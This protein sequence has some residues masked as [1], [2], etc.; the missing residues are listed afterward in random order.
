MDKYILQKIKYANSLF[1]LKKY[2]EA[3]NI[4]QEVF[5][6]LPEHIKKE[7][8]FNRQLIALRNKKKQICIDEK[9][10]EKSK[11]IAIAIHVFYLDIFSEILKAPLNML[12]M[13]DIIITV[14][15]DKKAAVEALLLENNLIATIFEKENKGYDILPFLE[16]IDY[17]IENKYDLILKLHTKKGLANLEEIYPNAGNIWFKLL[18]EP[19][20]GN[21][22][23][24]NKIINHFEENPHI[25]MLGS[26][27]FYKS[28]RK[29][30]Y[31]NEVDT[32][33][34]L[35]HIA[36]ER[37]I[38]VD[39]GFFAGSIFWLKTDVLKPL[40]KIIELLKETN[41]EKSQ[42]GSSNSLWHSIERIFGILPALTEHQITL[43][44]ANS[45][46]TIELIDAKQSR[47]PIGV[48]YGVGARLGGYIN[49]VSD[50]E[51]I[52]S[53]PDF[54]KN[55]YIKNYLNVK[56]LNVDPLYHY[57]RY[58]VYESCNPN[59]N[60][61]S[62][63]YWEA[64]R[65]V[66]LARINPLVHYLRHGKS[67]RPIF[68]AEENIQA[69]CN[70]LKKSNMFDS[71]FYLNEYPDVL[72][73]KMDPVK[74]YYLYGWK[75]K[76]YPTSLYNFDSIWYPQE[77]LKSWRCNINPLLHY[78]VLK[79]KSNIYPKPKV[80]R[81]G[82]SNGISFSETP[83]RI[84]LF[85]GYDPDGIIDEYV[86]EFIR[87]LSIYADVYYLADTIMQ[88]GELNK[89]NSITQGAWSFRHGEYDFGS[90]SRLA[91]DLVGWKLIETYDELLLVNDSSYL[92]SSLK[93]IFDK[94]N[95]KSCDWWG[96]QA[97]K[98]ISATR[99]IPSN[100]FKNKI[101][102]DLVLKNYLIN[103]EKDEVYDF[104]IGSYFLA[105]RK[106]C[107]KK[108]GE[109]QHIINNV[110]KEINKKNI[111][112]TYEIGLTRRLIL[113]GFKP[114][115][116]IDYLYPFHP[117][118]TNYHFDLIKNGFPLFK[119]FFLT[120]NHYFVPELHKWKEKIKNIL[121]STNLDSAEKN[122]LR[123][124]SP[125]K[126]YKTLNIPNNNSAWPPPLLS[127]DDFVK[128]DN[129]T[130][131]DEYCWAFPV[132][133]YDH[134]LTGNDRMV[135][136]S[137]RNNPKIHKIILTRSKHIQLSGK[138][139]TII[140]LKS[141][142][143]QRYLMMAKYIFIKHTPKENVLYPLDSERHKFIN[144]WHGIPLK[145]IGYT[146][147]DH[148]EIL[149]KISKVNNYSYTVIASSKVDRMAMAVAFYPLTYHDIWITGLPRNDVIL[150]EE[151]YLPL[152][153]QEQLIRLR[154]KL[155]NRRLILFAPTFRNKQK[156][157]YY[158]F[159]NAEKEKLSKLLLSYNAVL[160]VREHMADKA[161]SYT[162]KLI[163]NEMPVINLDKK[164]FSDIELIYRVSDILITDY[165]SCF[166]DFMLTGKPQICFAFDYESYAGSERGLFYELEDIFPG[167]VCHDFESLL[168]NLTLALQNQEI[169]EK[170]MYIHKR[171]IF[172]SYI[173]DKNT[174]RLLEYIQ[175]DSGVLL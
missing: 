104:H 126:L 27:D 125:E 46:N 63:Y 124:T 158:Q 75:E 120:E 3:D 13:C 171:K 25:G 5:N 30:M 103:Y 114:S 74:H 17:F 6:N 100:Q 41:N 121:P 141:L 123:I 145:R 151:Q 31:G 73:A 160:G 135:F 65:D 153:F 38:A 136:E 102:F 34:I 84:C 144:L 28:A 113:A 2:Q 112:L 91:K 98:G 154:Q 115:T 39:W 131:Q 118:Y 19:I 26:A 96:L 56:T 21:T 45:N 50:Y 140:P 40:L 170:Q 105:F 139:L 164:Y 1:R 149:D 8:N 111:I 99:E 61:S 78:V 150:R 12:N 52:E 175:K 133:A 128:E 71:A 90:Y 116:F 37:D 159:N 95:K 161:H 142:M 108:D 172:F 49:L 162:D 32:A 44:Y 94:M 55:F 93:P 109:L 89:L 29:L 134:L 23:Q 119:R 167:P 79:E 43:S 47:I 169:E 88:E 77:Y 64:N 85:A 48:P 22:D 9:N 53:T 16:L 174:D 129:M 60:F 137:V 18:M 157:G 36:P 97:T 163:G 10:N 92:I 130:T 166:I 155:A 42:T 11:K 152:D 7:I 156:D 146:S 66:S 54:D 76:R 82:L 80:E 127:N 106:P 72:R 69:I 83:K 147:L 14:S 59:E 110:K 143:G 101:P 132:C 57:L 67:G 68:P 168:T 70:L 20:F 148:I 86:V 15:S 24:V 51:F 117:I 58:G 62:A 173:D 165:S 33:Q 35:Q 87:E 4:Y 107:L 81:I 138:N 122:L